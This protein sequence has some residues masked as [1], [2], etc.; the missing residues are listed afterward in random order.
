MASVFTK[1]GKLF[2]V[3]PRKFKPQQVKPALLP[4][5]V[6]QA[7]GPLERVYKLKLKGNDDPFLTNP[8]KK[9][10]GTKEQPTLI[11]SVFDRRIVGCLCEEDMPGFNWI[12]LYKDQPKRCACGHW[13]KLK[14]V[15]SPLETV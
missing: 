1:I 14:Q 2:G 13:Y 10:P 11:P 15:K 12:W 8:I 4:D 6:A 5:A 7:T 9:G 3:A